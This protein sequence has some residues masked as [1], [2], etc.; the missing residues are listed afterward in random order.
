MQKPF[1]YVLIILIVF[2]GMSVAQESTSSFRITP[3]PVPC[4]KFF[5]GVQQ[6]SITGT[7][8]TMGE[9]EG[10]EGISSKPVAYGANMDYAFSSKKPL[11]GLQ[12]GGIISLAIMN[13]S[14]PSS[15]PGMEENTMGT[16]AYNLGFHWVLDLVNG[17]KRD[18][19]GE[20][21]SR[22]PTV[23]MFLGGVLNYFNL[24]MGP[25]YAGL[26]IQDD[27]KAKTLTS[28]YSVGLGADLPL[29]FVISLV[30]YVRYT[31]S[32]VS[33]TMKVPEMFNPSEFYDQTFTSSYDFVDY[34]TDIDIRPF[35]NAPDWVIS[36]GVALAQIEGLQNGNRLITVS[37]KHE[38]GK[39]YSSTLI[40]PRLH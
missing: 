16:N 29:G 24:N 30:P 9:L 7:H 13:I 38:I 17:E 36:V 28:N 27:V 3:P 5:P 39:Y 32:Q 23:A 10:Q 6:F 22:K 12:N 21:I 40:G 37:I 4:L 26:G 31:T 2:S 34:G 8:Y 15:L 19:A 20:I 25:I 18:I 33:M 11:L 35:R 14:I 1:L